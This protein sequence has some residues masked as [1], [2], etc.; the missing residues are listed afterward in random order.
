MLSFEHWPK[1]EC[2]IIS[3]LGA[4]AEQLRNVDLRYGIR[5]SAPT[6]QVFERQIGLGF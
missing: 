3:E 1:Q 2:L 4:S 5:S 6:H